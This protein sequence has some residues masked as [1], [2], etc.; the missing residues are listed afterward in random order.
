MDKVQVIWKYPIGPGPQQLEIPKGAK[1]LSVMKQPHEPTLSMWMQVDPDAEKEIRK[2]VTIPTG[3][4][5][6]QDCGT[7]AEYLG[8][9]FVENDTLV[10]HL[11]EI[12]F[13]DEQ[14]DMAQHS[15][16]VAAAKEAVTEEIRK[17]QRPGNMLHPA[18]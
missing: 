1:F 4:P 18:S 7:T 9:G 12:H 13:N 11:Y 15:E 5:F 3:R 10:F 16:A 14:E 8:T 17:Q 6:R 2:F